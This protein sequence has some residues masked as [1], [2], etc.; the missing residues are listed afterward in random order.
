M[1]TVKFWKDAAERAVKSG[2][3]AMLL[4]YLGGDQVFDAWHANWPAAGAIAAGAGLLSVLT[5][6]VS[7]RVGDSQS[8]SLVVDR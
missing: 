2:A 6:L 4:Y 8:A 5:S 7:S 3:Q 1:W